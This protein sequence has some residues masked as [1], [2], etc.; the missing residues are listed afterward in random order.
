MELLVIG[1]YRFVGRAVIDAAL[2]RGHAV[3][4]FNRGSTRA[5]APSAVEWIAG[6]RKHDLDALAGRR[7]DA[8]VDTC[9]F[10]PGPVGAAARAL[11][12]RV[13]HYGFVSSLSVY[14]WPVAAGTSERAPVDELAPGADP[15]GAEV[16]TYG[17]RKA[18]C[19]RAA[20]AALPGR[21]LSLRAGFI[22]GPHDYMDR[23]S[24][25]VERAAR[26]GTV[27]AP[28]RP[29][30]PLQLIDVA[31]LAE[32]AVTCAERGTVGPVNLSGPAA[33]PPPTMA[34]LLA[35]CAA[36]AGG[37]IEPVWVPDAFLHEAGV[38]EDVDLPYWCDDGES[39]IFAVDLARARATGLTTRPLLETARR[40]YAWRRSLAERTT[41]QGLGPERERE[42]LARF[43]AAS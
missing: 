42:L 27:L 20:E 36:A 16:E 7:W 17:Q 11:A 30:R 10:G 21:V 14:P 12:G 32:Y 18:L 4:A 35:A 40:T 26:G 13:G 25:W 23:F 31:D 34:E 33:G 38:R 8:V 9:G 19:E 41:R 22:V 6:D 28:G 5:A 15:D 3:T 2:A 39:G 43:R 37:D 29:D 1:G 24:Y